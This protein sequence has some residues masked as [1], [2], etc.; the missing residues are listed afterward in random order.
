MR[1]FPWILAIFVLAMLEPLIQFNHVDV[2]LDG[3]TILHDIN[4]QL[5]FGQHWAILPGPDEFGE[6][7]FLVFLCL[8]QNCVRNSRSTIFN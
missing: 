7:H 2:A 3:E 8:C 6:V 1:A 4:W 5:R